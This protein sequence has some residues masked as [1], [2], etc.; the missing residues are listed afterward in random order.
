MQIKNDANNQQLMSCFG[1]VPTCKRLVPGAIPT[2]NLPEKSIP[3]TSTSAP[4]REL[5]RHELKRK[6]YYTS[7]D[8]L[9]KKAEKLK[10]TGWSK[11]VSEKYATLVLW[12]EIYALPKLAVTIEDS[13]NLTVAVYNWLLPDEHTFYL[14]NKRS[15]R[16]TTLSSILS[17]LEQFQLCDGLPVDEPFISVAVDPSS[18]NCFASIIRHTV[19]INREQ[20]DANGPPFQTRVFRKK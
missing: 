7:L 11:S 13:L 4:R 1:I 16:H 20:Y 3:S 17:S 18:D 9:K 12:D 2:L 8:D 10:L 5:V 14:T 19:P 15:V 6:P